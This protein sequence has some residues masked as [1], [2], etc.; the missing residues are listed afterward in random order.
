MGVPE[1]SKLR[2]VE[3]PMKENICQE[4]LHTFNGEHPKN[5]MFMKSN[6]LASEFSEST[7]TFILINL[8]HI[9]SYVA[10]LQAR[11]PTKRTILMRL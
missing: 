10:Y 6:V 9:F 1:A 4:R 2:S 7:F 5:N 3:L 11:K 8:T